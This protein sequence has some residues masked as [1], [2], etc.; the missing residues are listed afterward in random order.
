MNAALALNPYA[1]TTT[2]CKLAEGDVVE[3]KVHEAI[4]SMLP[5]YHKSN[6][7]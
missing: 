3:H 2:A 4:E 1:S 7:Q 5:E 6:V